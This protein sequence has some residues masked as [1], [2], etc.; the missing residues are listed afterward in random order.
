MFNIY[1]KIVMMIGSLIAGAY[2]VHQIWLQSQYDPMAIFKIV[3]IV[4]IV[5]F[6]FTPNDILH[7]K[8]R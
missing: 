7:D 8:D 3:L 4:L 2:K 1:Y 5:G 6:V